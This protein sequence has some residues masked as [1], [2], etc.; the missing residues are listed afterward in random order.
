MLLM[1][2]DLCFAAQRRGDSGWTG[3]VLA[4][5]RTPRVLRHST[6]DVTAFVYQV[7]ECI[8][9]RALPS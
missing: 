9:R 4:P 3:K 8:L 7:A 2:I 6:S 1:S 5:S